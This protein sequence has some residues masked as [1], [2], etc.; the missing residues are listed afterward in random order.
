VYIVCDRLDFCYKFC[1]LL[2]VL[3]Q[4][5]DGGNGGVRR[6]Q[7]GKSFA[8][9]SRKID[10]RVPADTHQHIVRGVYSKAREIPRLAI[11]RKVTLKHQAVIGRQERVEAHINECSVQG[12]ITC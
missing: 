6:L 11:P 7:G 5:N 4:W 2:D 8:L 12:S 1:H 3:L 10:L 9:V